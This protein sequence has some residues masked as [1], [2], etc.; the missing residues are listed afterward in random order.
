M[1]STVELLWWLT[2]VLALVALALGVHVALLRKR[3][4]FAARKLQAMAENLEDTTIELKRLSGMDALTGVPNRRFFDEIL[5]KEWARAVRSHQPLAIIMI[6]ID[7]FK[8]HNDTYGHQAGD[9]CLRQVAN[10][11]KGSVHRPADVVARYGGE[12]FA[13]ILPGDDIVGA[14]AVAERMRLGV[15][16][17]KIAHVKSVSGHDVTI[18]LGVA[19][20][21]PDSHS[22]ALELVAAADEALYRAKAVGRN[23]V[24]VTDMHERESETI[25]L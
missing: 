4:R 20:V 1:T 10:V 21:V 9:V 11:L 13:L 14:A 8:L 18:S 7:R 17:L 15:E 6:D 24:I 3:L 25:D 5:D 23:Q 16:T 2:G 19:V 22:S 12:E